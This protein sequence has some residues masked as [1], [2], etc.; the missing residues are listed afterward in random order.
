MPTPSRLTDLTIVTI[1][2]VGYGDISPS[3]PAMRVFTVFYILI[4]CGLSSR[5]SP[6]PLL[7]CSKP[8]PAGSSGS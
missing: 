5:S 8:S 2:T 7:V 6:T 4:G 3:T 1:S